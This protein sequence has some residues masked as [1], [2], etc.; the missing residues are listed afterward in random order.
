MRAIDS[1]PDVSAKRALH[2]C[3]AVANSARDG[4]TARK[5]NPYGYSANCNSIYG[6]TNCSILPQSGGMWGGL[7]DGLANVFAKNRAAKNAAIACFA[8]RGWAATFK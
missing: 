2:V 5:S 7:A 8:D 6:N 1:K 3:R 4:T